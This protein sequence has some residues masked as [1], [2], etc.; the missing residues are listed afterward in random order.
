MLTYMVGAMGILFII[1]TVSILVRP[2][3]LHLLLTDWYKIK[4]AM[5]RFFIG[6]LLIVGSSATHWPWAMFYLGCIFIVLAVVFP[7]LGSERNQRSV[8]KQLLE[9]NQNIRI[10]TLAVALPISIFLIAS[11]FCFLISC[12]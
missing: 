8:K 5:I 1:M 7:L 9:N 6:I 4:N 10:Y 12:G 3:S 11:S 2:Q